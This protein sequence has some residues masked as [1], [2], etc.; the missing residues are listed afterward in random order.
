MLKSQLLVWLTII[1]LLWSAGCSAA[2]NTGGPDSAANQNSADK[3]VK[4]RIGWW[5]SRERHD[6]TLKI[7][8]LYTKKHPNVTFEPEYS[9]F[10]GYADK[11]ATQAAAKN[12]PDI[13]QMDASWLA[14]YNA[15]GYLA[16]L[17]G[18]N[19]KDVESGLLKEGQYAGKQTAMPLGKNAWGLIYDKDTLHKLG[20][21]MPEA[22]IT[23]D[24]FFKLAKE[25][26]MKLDKGHFVLA[27][28]TN[29]REM[30]TSYQLS[31]GLDYPVTPD[32]RFN[33]NKDLWLEWVNTFDELRKAGV[34]PPADIA[35]GDKDI[36]AKQDLLVTGKIIFKAAHAA[37]VSSWDTLKPGSIGVYTIPTDKQGGGWLKATFFFSVIQESKHKQEA[38]RFIDWFINDPEAAAISGTTRGV[39]VS[40][41]IVS[42]LEP[43]FTDADRLTIEMIDKASARALH[44]NPGAKGWINFD[45]KQYKMIAESIMFGKTTPEQGFEELK[46][47]A[48]AYQK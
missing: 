4:L 17:S 11:L 32:G 16:D 9:A 10:D 42:Q 31:K 24:Q 13:I 23:W 1:P 30:Y 22:G 25:I 12:A 5:G 35:V 46:Q 44:F 39:P 18:V 43:R 14:D 36:D 37:Q 15:R 33:F 27:D 47:T 48:A 38:I 8:A 41:K 6:A 19:T 28:F 21:D 29:N 3:P 34:V 40:D 20:F 2:M 26:K 45:T 7:L